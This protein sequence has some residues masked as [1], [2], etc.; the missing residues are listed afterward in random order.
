[1]RLQEVAELNA[2]A[3]VITAPL[4]ELI[5]EPGCLGWRGITMRSTYV[6][7]EGL[8]DTVTPGYVVNQP[9]ARVPY[10]RT[11][12]TKHASGQRVHG[13]VV[14]QEFSGAPGR[15]YPVPTVE[16]TYER[17]NDEL[18]RRI[19]DALEMPVF[20]CGRLANYAYINQDEAI[21]QAL[22]CAA[23]V[24]EVLRGTPALGRAVA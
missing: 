1:M 17:R 22:A 14:S 18:K 6:P 2:D 4:D 16:R 23:G 5:G 21:E 3:V 20:F 8:V 7:T 13:T 24:R 12:E 10:T 9:S 11:V 19:V 15:H